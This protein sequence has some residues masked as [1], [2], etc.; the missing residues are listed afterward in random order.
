MIAAQQ[1]EWALKTLQAL[2]LKLKTNLD[3]FEYD[4]KKL[5]KLK[6]AGML[7]RSSIGMAYEERALWQWFKGEL[8]PFYRNRRP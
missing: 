1:D 3:G 6:K 5:T 4:F 8:R 2:Q 7:K